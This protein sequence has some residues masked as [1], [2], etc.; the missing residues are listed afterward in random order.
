DVGT[1]IRRYQEGDVQDNIVAEFI[2]IMGSY[3]EISPSGKGVHIISKGKL[4]TGGSR[5]GNDEMYASGR[6]FTMTGN[7]I[8]GYRGITEDEE[9]K[10]NFLHE[11]YIKK[12]ST[13]SPANLPSLST[14]ND[15]SKQEVIQVAK[16]SKNGARFTFLLEGGW[17]QFYDSQ[18]E[19]DMAFANDLAFW[20]NRN[21]E[22]M[23]DIFRESSLYRDK[24]D[25]KTGDSTYGDITLN[26]AIDECTN[27]FKPRK[28][29]EDFNIYL[30]DEDTK[31]L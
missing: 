28:T 14:G 2:D 12:S 6:F 23:D 27:V 7:R 1:E 4:P 20:T 5:K 16:N 11:K 15:L 13:Q 10:I 18:S 17:E 22:M 9:G 19:A 24:W 25:R 31:R 29:D 30:L 3:A 26:K 21:Y 8:G